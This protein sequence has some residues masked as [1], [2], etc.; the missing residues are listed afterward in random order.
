MDFYDDQVK[1]TYGTCQTPALRLIVEQYE[2]KREYWV[3]NVDAEI[4]GHKFQLI[5]DKIFDQE[6]A[7]ELARK[8]QVWNFFKRGKI[9]YRLKGECQILEYTVYRNYSRISACAHFFNLF[10]T[11]KNISNFSPNIDF[12]SPNINFEDLDIDLYT[13]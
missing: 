6:A 2:A 8:L 9:V 12:E 10:K 7:N 13:G 11:R 5:S 1:M 3:V 4:N